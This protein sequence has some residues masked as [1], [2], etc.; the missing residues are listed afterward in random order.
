MSEVDAQVAHVAEGHRLAGWVLRGHG[1]TTASRI[2][3]YGG[4]SKLAGTYR[5]ACIVGK[6]NRRHAGIKDV[7]RLGEK[8]IWK[9]E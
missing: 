9:L 3:Q 5:H 7:V 4:T 6:P 1:V 8:E 2:V